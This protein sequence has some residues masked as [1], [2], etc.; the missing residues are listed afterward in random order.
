MVN[1]YI[2]E[3]D[4]AHIHAMKTANKCVALQKITLRNTPVFQNIQSANITR[5][6]IQVKVNIP[7]VFIITKMICK[8]WSCCMPSKIA[9]VPSVA[10]VP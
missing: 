10:S 2:G 4:Q 6:I 5:F 8:T 7:S 3:K 9:C 1:Y